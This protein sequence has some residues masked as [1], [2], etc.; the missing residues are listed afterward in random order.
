MRTNPQRD[1]AALEWTRDLMDKATRDSLITGYEPLIAALTLPD[2][3][4]RHAGS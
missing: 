3:D 2:P 4:D 1:R